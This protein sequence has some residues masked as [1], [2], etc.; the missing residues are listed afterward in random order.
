MSEANWK[1]VPSSK[2]V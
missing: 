2:I 1:L